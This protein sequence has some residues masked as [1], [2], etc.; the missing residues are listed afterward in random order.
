ML[1]SALFAALFHALVSLLM[2]LLA[3]GCKKI[4]ASSPFLGD[5][6]G[7]NGGRSKSHGGSSDHCPADESSSILY[8]KVK[9]EDTK[10][11]QYFSIFG[12]TG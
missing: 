9:N 7:N 2:A 6:Y 12:F 10:L 8:G 3:P 1:K 11:V 5:V 4:P